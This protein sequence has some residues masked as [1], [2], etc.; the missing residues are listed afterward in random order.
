MIEL[1]HDNEKC[2]NVKTFEVC[3]L[4]SKVN[5]IINECHIFKSSYDKTSKFFING[6]V[7]EMG[8]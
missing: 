8:S 7:T 5:Y 1:F 2:Y 6:W 4:H 3:F